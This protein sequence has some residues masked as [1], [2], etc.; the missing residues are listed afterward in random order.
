VAA[1]RDFQ[2]PFYYWAQTARGERV[3]RL[4]L[5]PLKDPLLEGRPVELEVVPISTPAR[6]DA[7]G[8]T[9]GIIGIDELERAKAKMLEL[10]RHL[11]DE[12]IA[13]F[14]P[15]RDAAACVYCA[16]RNACRRRPLQRA[17]PFGR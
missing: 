11:A 2:L 8:A 15:A 7:G 16:Y 4:M 17:D 5:V 13:A 9:A 3:S 12:P 1:F 14:P 6:Y 10:A